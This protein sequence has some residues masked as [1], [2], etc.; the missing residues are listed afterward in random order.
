[1][2]ASDFAINYTS[3]PVTSPFSTPRRREQSKKDA[4]LRD[5]ERMTK[6]AAG[7]VDDNA[8]DSGNADG[9]KKRSVANAA[10]ARAAKALEKHMNRADEKKVALFAEGAPTHARGDGAH[11][12]PPPIFSS[13]PCRHDAPLLISPLLPNNR[14]GSQG[15]E[16]GGVYYERFNP[17]ELAKA[18]D[19]KKLGGRMEND[20]SNALKR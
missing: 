16:P 5:I 19:L 8:S 11:M 15:A 9:P 12:P 4:K 6:A 10:A 13:C 7:D 18:R 14:P 2:N 3:F 20:L 17:P 1:M